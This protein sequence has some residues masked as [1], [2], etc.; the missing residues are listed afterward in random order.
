MR[1]INRIILVLF[2]LCT[3]LWAKPNVFIP[4][5]ELD[6]VHQDYA[7]K[8]VQVTKYHMES[9]KNMRVVESESESDCIL[10]IKML[11]DSNDVLVVYSL[12]NSDDKDE[13]W[14]YKHMVYSPE[15]FAP[16][17]DVATTKIGRWN[18]F[19]FGL[20]LGTL[21]L[22]LPEF[23]AAPLINLS[24]HYL[25]NNVLFSLDGNWG[26]DEGLGDDDFTYIG[27]FLSVAYVL[28]GRRFFPYVGAGAGFSFM[29]YDSNRYSFAENESGEGLTV[30]F[31]AG[32]FFK[33][34]GYKTVFAID[35]RYLN[36]FYEIQ[37]LFDESW[38]MA[39]G[40][41]ISAQVWW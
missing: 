25:Y 32:V 1:I 22:A 5:V 21:G 7:D 34:V 15:D 33:P 13:T 27:A 8:L 24:A 9:K 2:F 6:G 19:R 28:D 40:W 37:N 11:C 20:G 30:F 35:V 18:G 14:S 41:S 12:Q 16:V 3:M 23:A 4:A 39:R 29:E 31:K 10:Q 38:S 17:A 36:N 26:I